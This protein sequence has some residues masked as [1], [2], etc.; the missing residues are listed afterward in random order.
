MYLCAAKSQAKFTPEQAEIWV[1]ALSV[2]PEPVVNKAVMVLVACLDPFPDLAKVLRECHNISAAL[3][4]NV[5]AGTYS[6]SGRAP[7][8]VVNMLAKQLGLE[9][10]R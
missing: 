6:D 1:K 8:A 7:L 10:A 3:N 2:Y 9:I 5:A 4:P